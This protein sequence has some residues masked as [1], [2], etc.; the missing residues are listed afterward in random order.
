MTKSAKLRTILHILDWN[1]DL[2]ACEN[3]PV[4]AQAVADF[5]SEYDWGTVSYGDAVIAWVEAAGMDLSTVS[6]ADQGWLAGLVEGMYFT[7]GA[8]A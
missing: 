2:Q 7:E 6:V 3:G 8:A 5:D 4:T 1:E